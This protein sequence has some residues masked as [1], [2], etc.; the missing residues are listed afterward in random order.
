MRHLKYRLSESLV[1]LYVDR[2]YLPGL[3]MK[4]FWLQF[5]FSQLVIFVNLNAW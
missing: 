5:F 1:I 4:S 2:L 3:E